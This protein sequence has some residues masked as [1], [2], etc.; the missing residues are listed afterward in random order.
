[1]IYSFKRL[2]Y[3]K[4]F[5]PGNPTPIL[6]IGWPFVWAM[7]VVVTIV[8]S[9]VVLGFFSFFLYMYKYIYIFFS[10]LSFPFLFFM[11]FLFTISSHNRG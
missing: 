5:F 1:M 8:Y 7:W 11:Y 6:A 4:G 2:V 10:L 9:E 3:K